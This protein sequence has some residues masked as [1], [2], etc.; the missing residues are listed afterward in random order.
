MVEVLNEPAIFVLCG[1]SCLTYTR[2][3]STRFGWN[4]KLSCWRFVRDRTCSLD[5]NRSLKILVTS[6]EDN[7]SWTF[8]YK[9]HNRELSLYKG[10]ILF[11]FLKHCYYCFCHSLARSKL[12]ISPAFTDREPGTDFLWPRPLNARIVYVVFTI[13]L[14][15]FWHSRLWLT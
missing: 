2:E 13:P 14:L 10:R 8:K 9:S 1:R 3:C 6:S 5:W 12:W 4:R 11:Y 15:T 7:S